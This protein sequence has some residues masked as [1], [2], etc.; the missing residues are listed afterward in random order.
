MVGI[1]PGPRQVE[2]GGS[3]NQ[4]SER[5]RFLGLEMRR[6]L[7]WGAQVK[8]IAEKCQNP[9]QIISCLRGGKQTL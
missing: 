2:L 3:V 4:E 5:V 6:N 9:L 7:E 8:S 1:G